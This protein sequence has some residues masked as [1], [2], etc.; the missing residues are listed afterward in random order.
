MTVKEVNKKK[1]I[2][3]KLIE[4][5]LGQSQIPFIYFETKNYCVSIKR[6]I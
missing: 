6:K 2:I 5:L 4:F 1:T 3:G